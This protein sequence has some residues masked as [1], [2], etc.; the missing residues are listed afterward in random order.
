M[1]DSREK[2]HDARKTG[3]ANH[4]KLML[5]DGVDAFVLLCFGKEHDSSIILV[6]IS[7]PVDETVIWR[8][9]TLAWCS[10]RAGGETISLSLV[11]NALT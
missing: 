1:T 6:S 8:E 3:L 5:G 2:A 7:D 9:V 10:R 4:F 11:W